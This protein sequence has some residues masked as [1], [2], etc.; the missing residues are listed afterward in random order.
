M[1]KSLGN[2]YTVHELLE[3]FPGEALR[4]VLLKSQYRQPLDF[5]KDKLREAKK[6]LDKFYRLIG[7][8]SEIVDAEEDADC[9]S[10]LTG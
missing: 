1:S 9:I 8:A 7:D 6:E 4:L 2:F 5:S 3:E 10:S